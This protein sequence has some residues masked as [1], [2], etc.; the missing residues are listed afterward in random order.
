MTRLVL[1]P[2]MVSELP[3]R[4]PYLLLGESF[5]GPIALSIAARRPALLRGV[6]LC[7]SFA[8]N[9]RPALKHLG[10]LLNRLPDRPPVGPLMWLLAGRFSSPE[11]REAFSRALTQVLA[12]V[13]GTRTVELVAP[14]FLLQT[15]PQEAARVIE[16]FMQ[17]A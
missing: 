14:H 17:L 3:S 1:L 6:V 11:L 7:C 13:P 8:C 15:R 5:S 16:E 12:N 2:G 10:V 9:P 4:E